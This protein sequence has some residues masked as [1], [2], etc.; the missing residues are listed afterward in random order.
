ML[1][2]GRARVSISSISAAA[3]T[4][5]RMEAAATDGSQEARLSTITKKLGHLSYLGE[6]VDLVRG[7]FKTSPLVWRAAEARPCF[8]LLNSFVSSSFFRLNASRP[9]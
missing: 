9:T 3:G 6:L 7:I 5:T 1:V 4:L 8:S 2:D